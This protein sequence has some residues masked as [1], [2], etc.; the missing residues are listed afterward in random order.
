MQMRVKTY[1]GAIVLLSGLPVWAQS[2]AQTGSASTAAS[3][4]DG[5]NTISIGDPG[6]FVAGFFTGLV[7][8]AVAAK[9]FG[10]SKPNNQG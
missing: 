5:S 10:G 8:G 1:R 2:G 7:V 6:W 4:P 9:V 3:A